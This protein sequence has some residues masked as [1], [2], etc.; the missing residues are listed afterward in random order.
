MQ[1]SAVANPS[2]WTGT[3]TKVSAGSAD[4]F[5]TKVNA[6]GSYGWTHA[7]GGTGNNEHGNGI[8]TDGSG[9]VYVTGT[10]YSTV[11]FAADWSGTDSKSSVNSSGGFVTKVAANG[12]YG[13]THMVGAADS[14]QELRDVDTDASGNIYVCG[15]FSDALNFAADWSGSDTKTP[16]GSSTNGFVTR[17]DADGSYGWTRFFG[18]TGYVN[19]LNIAVGSTGVYVGGSFTGTVDFDWGAGTDEKSEVGAG[20]ECFVVKI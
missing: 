15:G 6:D 17:V 8:S 18:G 9:N 12:T 13:W 11:N 3:D 20:D 2:D 7:M 5:V 1:A 4:I 19:A 10:F 16:V 14:A